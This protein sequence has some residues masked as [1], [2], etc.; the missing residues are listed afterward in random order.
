M[1][2]S[3]FFYNCLLFY[4]FASKAV[5]DSQ[6]ESQITIARR[7]FL[8]RSLEQKTNIIEA[9]LKLNNT[10][11]QTIRHKITS[12]S[13]IRSTA[14]FPGENRARSKGSTHCFCFSISFVFLFL[15]STVYWEVEEAN[16]SSVG[17]GL[18]KGKEFELFSH[19]VG[20]SQHSVA[21]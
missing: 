8:F 11:F 18:A 14:T 7:E 15:S 2:V 13:A 19:L 1:V 10:P 3:V 9:R 21:W 4:C 20:I 16:W 12:F 5:S 17:D 6:V